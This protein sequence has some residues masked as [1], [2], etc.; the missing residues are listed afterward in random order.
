LSRIGGALRLSDEAF[1]PAPPWIGKRVARKQSFAAKVEH[2]YSATGD[3]MATSFSSGKNPLGGFA[4]LMI[5]AYLLL[6]TG[7]R[8]GAS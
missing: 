3:Q 4:L 7:A 1:D 8:G 6:L 2:R 5:V